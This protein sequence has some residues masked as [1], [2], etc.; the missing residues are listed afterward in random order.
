MRQ[1][2]LLVILCVGTLALAGCAGNKRIV[3]AAPAS[4]ST[5][6]P[7]EAP[8]PPPP[9][10]APP[11][12]VPKEP[13]AEIPLPTPEPAPPKRPTPRPRPTPAEAEPAQPK[14]AAP[15][16]SPQLSAKDLAAAKGRT[17]ANIT[18][19]EKNLQA[20]NGKQLTAAQKDL[21]EKISGF[22]N[23]AHEAIVAEDWVRAQNLADK[24]R[25][26]ST[27]LVNSF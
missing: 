26:L 25:V 9:A 24:A 17:S 16:I 8:A 4:V 1:N 22:L 23:Q 3:R 12:E 2:N 19:A 11:A 15:Q 21:T 10:M 7:A 5:A 14:P 18:T 13:P 6:P 20:T 27:E